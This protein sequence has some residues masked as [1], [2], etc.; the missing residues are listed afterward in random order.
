MRIV[1][2]ESTMKRFNGADI[3][4]TRLYVKNHCGTFIISK[5]D[6]HG[7][8]YPGNK[9]ENFIEPIY[10]D[11][12]MEL[13]ITPGPYTEVEWKEFQDKMVFNYRYILGKRIFAYVTGKPDISY[14]V[15]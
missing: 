12:V 6:K 7:L 9:G 13:E 3:D 5:L 11:S 10:P 4:Q 1:A 8:S 15:A 2:K 14:A